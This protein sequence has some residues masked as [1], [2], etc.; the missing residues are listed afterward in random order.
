MTIKR[1]RQSIQELTSRYKPDFDKS[2][3]MKI[4]MPKPPAVNKK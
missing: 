1:I 4:T 2:A 3:F